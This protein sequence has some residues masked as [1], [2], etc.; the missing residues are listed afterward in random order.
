MEVAEGA[1]TRRCS[2]RFEGSHNRVVIHAG[3]RLQRCDISLKGVGLHLVIGE[4]VKVSGAAQFRLF[5]RGSSIRIGPGTTIESARIA[6]LGG[7]TVRVGAD[8]ML[9]YDIDIRNS[10]SHSLID[11][12]SGE[13]LNPERDVLVGDHVWI[14]A[15]AALLRGATLGSHCVVGLG[16]IVTKAFPPHTVLAGAPARAVREDVIWDRRRL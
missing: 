4:N 14:G 2:L 15:R 5:D 9:A 8:C 7:A 10:D 1:Q 16:S 3:A 6:S 13:R 11:R 12:H